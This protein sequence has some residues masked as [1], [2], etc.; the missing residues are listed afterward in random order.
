ME[1]QGFIG[2]GAGGVEAG[3]R[4]FASRDEARD[5]LRKT[6]ERIE[7]DESA[8]PVLRASGMRALLT[9]PDLDLSIGFAAAKDDEHFLRWDFV[10][11]GTYDAKL[12]MTMRAAVANSLLQGAE[13]VPVAVARGRIRVRGGGMAALV[14][15]S[16]LRMISRHYSAVL[17]A[18]H[19][20][21]LVD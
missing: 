7:S 3:E 4:T 10:D 18:E 5:V 6:F 19:P 15:L 14:H 9:L 21:L 8:G 1:A 2:S 13:S 12:T 16:A 20:E 11:A 17:R